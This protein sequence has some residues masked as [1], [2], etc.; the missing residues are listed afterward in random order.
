[1]TDK[2][3]SFI[4]AN[5]SQKTRESMMTI[6]FCIYVWGLIIGFKGNFVIGL[7][8]LLT[9]ISPIIIG[10]VSLFTLGHIN[11]SEIIGT[12]LFTTE[13][14][15]VVGVIFVTIGIAVIA[16][17]LPTIINNWAKNKITIK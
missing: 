11:L 3:R 15:K 13:S 10:I 6:C 17:N 5:F 2:I 4:E 9:V 12:W 7:L 16:F 14:G 8:S 1:M